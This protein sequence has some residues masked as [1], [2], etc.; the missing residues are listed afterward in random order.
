MYDLAG[1]AIVLNGVDYSAVYD[2]QYYVNKYADI[3]KAYGYDD[4]AVL[5]HFVNYGMKEGRQAKSSFD[6]NSYRL[7][8]ADL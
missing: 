7:Q 5:Q 1:A 2:Y 3:K 6:V 8:Y 4:L